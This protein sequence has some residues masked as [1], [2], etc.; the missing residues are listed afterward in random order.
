MLGEGR[1]YQL[2]EYTVSHRQ[3]LLRSVK[4]RGNASRVD[5]LF[6]DVQRLE[7]D[8]LMTS[9]HIEELP[10]LDGESYSRWRLSYEEG[11][12][13]IV[14][15]IMVEGE[16]EGEY[17]NASPVPCSPMRAAQLDASVDASGE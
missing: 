6:K 16:D 14:A 13:V 5:I 10:R 8:P 17:W 2:W 11:T 3:L 12:G 1:R 4:G 9:L 7:I 15:G